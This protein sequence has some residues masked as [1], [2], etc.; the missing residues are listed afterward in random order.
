MMAVLGLVLAMAIN[1]YVNSGRLDRIVTIAGVLVFTALTA[2][3]TQHN[4]RIKDKNEPG[5]GCQDEVWHLRDAQTLSRLHQH[6]P[7]HDAAVRW[8]PSLRR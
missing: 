3:D 4:G 1:F 6:T 7:L 8:P 2:F 5:R